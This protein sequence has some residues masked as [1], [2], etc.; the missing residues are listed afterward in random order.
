MDEGFH[1]N[2]HRA[3]GKQE[4]IQHATNGTNKLRNQTYT[5]IDQIEASNR[6]TKST[7]IS[8]RPKEPMTK[9]AVGEEA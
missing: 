3:T 7:P 1:R 5:E 8:I 6:E 2:H 4:N 9:I